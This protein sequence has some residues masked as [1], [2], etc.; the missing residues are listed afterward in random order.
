MTQSAK[1]TTRS[2]N[3]TTRPLKAQKEHRQEGASDAD[4]MQKVAGG[5]TIEVNFT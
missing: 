4:E 1:D 2:L 5:E 3:N